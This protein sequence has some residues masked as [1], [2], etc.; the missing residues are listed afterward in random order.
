MISGAN[1]TNM[2][3]MTT[4]Y[5]CTTHDWDK[6]TMTPSL[7]KDDEMLHFQVEANCNKRTQ[8]KK[9]YDLHRIIR[10]KRRL[11][12]N[13]KT[14][15]SS[16]EPSII[17]VLR[18]TCQNLHLHT[19]MNLYYK[20]VLQTWIRINQLEFVHS[21][22]TNTNPRKTLF[23]LSCDLEKQNMVMGILH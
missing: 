10:R 13:Q 14:Y 3:F 20:S 16:S 1:D 12:H 4:L 21:N 22:L 2:Q 19:S 6:H 9:D 18:E 23:S 7:V 15:F 5:E 11:E 8:F 17:R